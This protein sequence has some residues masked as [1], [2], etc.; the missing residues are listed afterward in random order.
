MSNIRRLDSS[1]RR[2]P[3]ELDA[4]LKRVGASG[5]ELGA[6]AVTYWQVE[7]IPEAAA[8]LWLS[9][10]CRAGVSW[11]GVS[12]WTQ[13]DSPEDAIRRVCIVGKVEDLR[14]G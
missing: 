6:E 1:A 2:L 11:H 8:C 10:R 12:V 9:R 4:E 13:A 5:E 7:G 14:R 3:P